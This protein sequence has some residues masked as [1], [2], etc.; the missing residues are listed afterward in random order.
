MSGKWGRP[1]IKTILQG[2]LSAILTFTLQSGRHSIEKRC[3]IVVSTRIASSIAKR[4]PM[5]MRGPPPN[6]I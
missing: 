6:G 4:W 3:A 1:R 2:L 5:Q